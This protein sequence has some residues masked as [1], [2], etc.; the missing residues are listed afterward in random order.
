MYNS[1]GFSL[2]D[3]RYFHARH[4]LF[5]KGSIILK[6]VEWSD[7]SCVCVLWQKNLYFWL[8]RKEHNEICICICNI[9]LKLNPL[10]LW[11]LYFYLYYVFI[12]SLV[13]LLAIFFTNMLLTCRYTFFKIFVKCITLQIKKHLQYYITSD[14][15]FT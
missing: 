15:V 1:P 10:N 3:K 9:C 13:G 8:Q 12:W 5:S 4:D 7:N 14:W 11:L 6:L 2:F